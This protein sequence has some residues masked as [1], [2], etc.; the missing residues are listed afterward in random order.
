MH[1]ADRSF[2]IRERILVPLVSILEISNKL[3]FIVSDFGAVANFIS[4]SKVQ[5]PQSIFMGTR[6][7]LLKLVL[8]CDPYERVVVFEFGVA[9]GALTAWGLNQIKSKSLK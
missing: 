1:R 6:K 2:I 8:K 5:F 7:I 3:R 9:R 4:R